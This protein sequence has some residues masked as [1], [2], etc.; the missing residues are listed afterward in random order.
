QFDGCSIA[1]NNYQVGVENNNI[2]RPQSESVLLSSI[3]NLLEE[4]NSIPQNENWLEFINPDL[5]HRLLNEQVFDFYRQLYR[6]QCSHL[7]RIEQAERN[8]DLQVEILQALK[9]ESAIA[10]ALLDYAKEK[11][12]NKIESI[13][14]ISKAPLNDIFDSLRQ[15][16]YEDPYLT[17]DPKKDI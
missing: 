12:F 11:L 16:D 1:L 10:G 14:Y 5:F 2:L 13:F 6:E 8:A 7:I 17:F 4:T 3:A 9:T 15:S